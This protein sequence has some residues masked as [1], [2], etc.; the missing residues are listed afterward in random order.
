MCFS[1][2]SD[3]VRAAIG[4]ILASGGSKNA[5]CPTVAFLWENKLYYYSLVLLKTRLSGIVFLDT[6]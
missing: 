2:T 4:N 6:T 5:M 1:F 3:A